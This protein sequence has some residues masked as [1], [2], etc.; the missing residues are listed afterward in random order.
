M[1]I[2]P[3]EI[4]LRCDGEVDFI[5]SEMER[6]HR[7]AQSGAS[8]TQQFGDGPKALLEMTAT[9]PY[10]ALNR[11]FPCGREAFKRFHKLA[12]ILVG[13]R[14]DAP[15]WDTAVLSERLRVTFLSYLFA[16][17]VKNTEEMLEP[18]LAA[19]VRYVRARHRPSVHYLPCVAL[20][21]G[22]KNTYNF[23]AITFTRKRLFFEEAK[24]AFLSYGRARQRL[25][26]RIRRNAAPELKW[27]WK[28]LD[29]YKSK[30]VDEAFEEITK[31][32]DW[33][34]IVRVP[35]CDRS[36]AEKRA[37]QAL[38]IAL[39]AQTVL[40][41]GTEGAGLRLAADAFP[42]S[43]TNKLSSIGKG[44]LRP[45]SSWKFGNPKT[46]EGWQ[47]YLQSQ[48]KPVLSV[49]YHLIE[50]TLSGKTMP[51]GFLIASRAMSWY[52]DAVRD[53]NPETRLI[54]CAT[55]VECLVFPEQGKATSTFVIRGALLAQRQ[56]SPMKHWAAVARKLYR[57]RSAVAHGDLE[58]LLSFRGDSTSEALEFSRNVILQ[59]L[60]FCV[61]L[62]PIGIE[63][64]G[65]KQDF[66]E[67]YEQ[68]EAG[69][70]KEIDEIVKTY[71]FSKWKGVPP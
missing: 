40:L 10:A 22:Q 15:D 24:T 55:A 56:G 30:S 29:E 43:R 47:E 60:A 50:Q 46:E 8:F 14:P 3:D 65:S 25:D 19:G 70:S 17:G 26:Q 35:R 42:L 36:V 62:Q 63:R 61:Q 18:W 39:S 27:C 41:Q 33:I 38:R 67:L 23:G 16:E 53:S 31:G 71:N 48:A 28:D 58:T 4:K 68:C 9:I 54:K 5:V 13:Y 37:E 64:Q 32:A 11:E 52:A 44:M 66:L 12:K 57:Q 1:S 21:I 34:A 59:F 7:L 20:Q 2:I 51:Y 49:I 69:F 6:F 45:S